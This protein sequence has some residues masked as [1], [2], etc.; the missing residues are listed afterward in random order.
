MVL[1]SDTEDVGFNLG[2]GTKVPHAK[3]HLTLSVAT[4]EPE[5]QNKEPACWS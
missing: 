3:Q 4:T 2:Q 5:Q 1:P